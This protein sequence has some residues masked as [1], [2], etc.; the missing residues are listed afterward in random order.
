[1]SPVKGLL[2]LFNSLIVFF[3]LKILNKVKKGATLEFGILVSVGN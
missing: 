1:M 2:P 3:S